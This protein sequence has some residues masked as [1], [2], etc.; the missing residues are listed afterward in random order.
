MLPRK[1]TPTFRNDPDLFTLF[2]LAERLGKTVNELL[3]GVVAPISN[4]EVEYWKSFW[5]YR[6]ELEEKENE[7]KKKNR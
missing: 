7:K 2:E 6:R 1:R 5:A 3:S 4:R